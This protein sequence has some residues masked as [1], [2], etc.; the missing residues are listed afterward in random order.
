MGIVVMNRRGSKR[1]VPFIP[2]LAVII[3]TLDPRLAAPLVEPAHPEKLASRRDGVRLLGDARDHLEDYPEVLGHLD[4]RLEID[5]ESSRDAG[6]R[7]TPLNLL[8][9]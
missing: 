2:L 9:C 6:A 8:T 5:V 4:T 7:L 1:G 3:E